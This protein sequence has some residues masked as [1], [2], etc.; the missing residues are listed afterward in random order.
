MAKY[1]KAYLHNKKESNISLPLRF[2]FLKSI[3][4]EGLSVKNV[5]F[6]TLRQLSNGKYTILQPKS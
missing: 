6:Y 4:I 5:P 1:Y 3:F 2:S